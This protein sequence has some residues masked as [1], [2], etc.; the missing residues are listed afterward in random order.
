MKNIKLD[1]SNVMDFITEE[2]IEQEKKKYL[3]ARKK[4]VE[5]SGEGSDYLGWLD[6]PKRITDDEIDD[7]LETAAHIREDSDVFISVGIGGS[8]LGARAAIEALSPNFYNMSMKPQIYFAGNSISPRYLKDLKSVID[9]K[10]VTINIISKSG[11]T[12]EP[13]L[14][15][16]MIREWMIENYGQKDVFK[17]IVA[18]TD[19]SK[20]ALRQ[21]ADEEGIKTFVIPDDVGGRFSVLTP[22]GLLP[23]AVAGID[24]RKM[25][26]GAADGMKEFRDEEDIAKNPSSMYAILRNI[27]YEKGKRIEM[28]SN[29]EPQLHYISE[30]WKQLFGE[31]EGKDNKGLHPTSCDFT[32]DL[33]SM[34]QW[35]QDGCRN[36]IETFLNVEDPESTIVIG[37]E[38]RN[39]DHLNY[40]AGK[41]FRYVNEQA[42]LGTRA[43]H[44]DGEVP[45]MTITIP[46]ISPYYIGNLFY[47]FEWAVAVSGY[48][49]GVNPFNQPGVES[50]KKN[51]FA[52]LGKPGFEEQ[53][54][55]IR[56]KL[57]GQ[58]KFISAGSPGKAEVGAG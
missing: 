54:R 46:S 19:S 41:T 45:N 11:T 57:S 12:T 58:K 51:M 21:L 31:S 23:I 53:S 33:H 14:A 28:L 52:L 35:I 6:L 37:M 42:F 44:R 27:L 9:G 17:R 36:I 10:K 5:K 56:E 13:A 20:G 2:D 47:F 40:L 3:E 55:E 34:G 7:I 38:K 49:L 32:T 29:F 26:E 39:L 15:F 18:T 24:I 25:L 30:W 8:Y 22:V 1:Y 16:R 4:V 48:M 43:A 50:Y